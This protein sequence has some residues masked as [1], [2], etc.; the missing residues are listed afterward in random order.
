MQQRYY[1]PTVGRFWSADPAN[2]EFSRFD[3]ARNNP[4]LFTD[5]DGRL[6]GS[7]AQYHEDNTPHEPP[8][9]PVSP[10]VQRMRDTSDHGIAGAS[11]NQNAVAAGLYVSDGTVTGVAATMTASEHVM[12]KGAEMAPELEESSKMLAEG[13]EHS[14]TLARH[15]A[16]AGFVLDAKDIFYGKTVADQAHGV[17]GVTVSAVTS[18]LLVPEVGVA[19][20]VVDFRMQEKGGWINPRISNSF[21]EEGHLP[22]R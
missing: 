20:D 16:W 8:K 4:F 15:V 10:A 7:S 2:S 14:K 5:P 19:Y 11:A 1:D 18:V 17:V 3:Y 13:A 6:A 9:P 22:V 21:L 12:R